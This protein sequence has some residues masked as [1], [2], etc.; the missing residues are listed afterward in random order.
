MDSSESQKYISGRKLKGKLEQK[1]ETIL[2]EKNLPYWKDKA[3]KHKEEEKYEINVDKIDFTPDFTFVIYNLIMDSDVTAIDANKRRPI[4]IDDDDK[5]DTKDHLLGIEVYLFDEE[6][7]EYL[8]N[9]DPEL[10]LELMITCGLINGAYFSQEPDPQKII[11]RLNRRSANIT[12]IS[13]RAGLSS[14]EKTCLE[15]KQNDIKDD[16]ER[17]H[18]RQKKQHPAEK[19]LRPCQIAK[20]KTREVAS[21]LWEKDPQ[22][23]IA[24]MINLSEI[25]EVSKKSELT[26]YTEKTMRNW[27]KD[28]CPNRKPGRRKQS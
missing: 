11:N 24:D 16:I 20:N 4:I 13:N 14:R 10:I 5:G 15:K 8:E 3:K 18:N 9:E 28:L 7:I 25:L 2:R 21:K 1:W 23:T 26:Y 22:M 19:R 6:E 12:A 17:E 27:I